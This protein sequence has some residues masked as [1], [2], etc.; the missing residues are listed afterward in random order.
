[1]ERGVA[2]RVHVGRPKSRL[3]KRLAPYLLIAPGGLW[4]LIFF[5]IPIVF[6]ASVSLPV[7]TGPN[8]M[9]IGLQILARRHDDR[10][11]FAWASSEPAT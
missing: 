8:N 9:P 4:L 2:A 1:M 11:L 3:G 10:K 7:F 5:L 6:M